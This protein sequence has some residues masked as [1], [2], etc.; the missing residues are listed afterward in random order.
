M[1]KNISDLDP[2]IAYRVNDAKNKDILSVGD[3]KHLHEI[4]ANM[5]MR[6]DAKKLV[7][8]FE[9]MRFR[10]DTIKTNLQRQ[11]W[12]KD[13]KLQAERILTKDETDE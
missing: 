11:G 12:V 5:K 8:N 9:R 6:E 1:E 13:G 4:A 7:L 2:D 10:M 3:E